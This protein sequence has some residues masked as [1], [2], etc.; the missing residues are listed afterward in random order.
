MRRINWTEN[1]SLQRPIDNINTE[2]REK[3]FMAL[4]AASM[5]WFPLPGDQVFLAD[6]AKKVAEDLLKYLAEHHNI[7]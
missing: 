5:C 4:G 7:Y 3:V 2:L 6:E 1:K